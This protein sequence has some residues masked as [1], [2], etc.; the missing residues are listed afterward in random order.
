[1]LPNLSKLGTEPK[2][3]PTYILDLPSARSD[4]AFNDALIG[5]KTISTLTHMLIVD[6]KVV[7]SF[8]RKFVLRDI[9]HGEEWESKDTWTRFARHVESSDFGVADNGSNNVKVI[10]AW[11]LPK[12]FIRIF[13]VNDDDGL[14]RLILRQNKP[15]KRP[16]AEAAATEIILTG[17]AAY[18]GLGPKLFAA[19]LD[20]RGAH[21]LVPYDM[22]IYDAKRP[23]RT[24]KEIFLEAFGPKTAFSETLRDSQVDMM[25]LTEEWE[26]YNLFHILYHNVVSPNMFAT[27]LSRIL[28][29]AARCGFWHLDLKTAN[30]LYR[31]NG[32]KNFELCFT[33]F[34]GVHCYVFPPTEREEFARCN[35]MVHATMLLGSMSCRS[36]K[37]WQH[38][39]AAVYNTLAADYGINAVTAEELCAFL[40]V[41]DRGPKRLRTSDAKRAVA[42]RMLFSMEWYLGWPGSGAHPDQN[43]RCLSRT[44]NPE[45][46]FHQFFEFALWKDSQ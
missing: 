25:M 40:D 1:M 10:K 28:G 45:P 27:A 32:T 36:R 17:Y 44:D 31:W 42:N 22:T 33:D 35:V 12:E 19:T 37:T 14:P 21:L 20:D 4:P 46:L 13:D 26:G 43:K 30:M 29:V 18:H 5:T 24:T 8:D 11:P 15:E 39:R 6:S 9:G 38:Y 16:T 7:G 41:A 23:D 2:P 3:A 34:D